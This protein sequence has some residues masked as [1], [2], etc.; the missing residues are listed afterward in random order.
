MDN[1]LYWLWLTECFGAGNKRLW[2]VLSRFDNE[3]KLAFEALSRGE[4][5][6]L[7]PTEKYNTSHVKLSKSEQVLRYCTAR[8][9]TVI[10]FDS[11]A[12]PDRLRGIYNPPP[13]LFC[14]GDLG[15]IDDD[16][17]ITVVGARVPSEY[18]VTLAARICSELA[19]VGITIVSGFAL[20]ID[21]S[22]HQGALKVHGK[23]IAVLGC[24]LDVSYPKENEAAKLRIAENG[25]VVTEFLP[26]TPPNRLNFPQRNRILSGLSLGTLVVEAG[27]RSGSL[28]T[29]ELALSQGRDVFCIPPANLFDERYSGVIKLLRDGA[30]PTFNHLDILYEY[31]ENFSHRINSINPYSS[32]TSKDESVIFEQEILGQATRKPIKNTTPKPHK[33]ALISAEIEEVEDT[34][35]SIN[36]DELTETEA[37]AVRLIAERGSV[38]ADEIADELDMSVSELLA[39]LTELELYGI[40][41]SQAGNRFS[42]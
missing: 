3:P 36:F 19:L 14:M 34:K 1:V 13:V 31:Y 28:I 20:G 2:E 23:T 5:A 15:S 8:N 27:P 12:Y 25:A 11:E 4:V 38:I 16:V 22:A 24:G 29:A 42:L 37:K 32:Y 35:E 41:K 10:P 18:S 21:S 40:V 9:Y 30:I 33:E 39:L 7:S 26:N 6:G 17:A